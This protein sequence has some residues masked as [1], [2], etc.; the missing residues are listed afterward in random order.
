MISA[1]RVSFNL[2]L[3]R[4]A[5]WARKLNLPL[6]ILEVLRVDCR[7]ASD[8]L[9]RFVIDGM[10]DTDRRLTN[11]PVTYYPYVEPAPG[12]GRGLLGAL[13]K[14][15][16]VVVTDD[17]PT[18]FLKRM[19][20][21]AATQLETRLEAVDGNGL[22][23][24]A[25]ADREFS[26]AHAFRRFLQRSLPEHMCEIPLLDPLAEALPQPA[27]VSETITLRW[28]KASV[29]LLDG[30]RT[31]I[32]ALPI[33]HDVEPDGFRGGASAAEATLLNFLDR[34]LG[35][36]LEI[37]NRPDE[38]GT[39]GL[40]PYLHFGHLSVHQVFVELMARERWTPE[41]LSGRNDGRRSGWW[42]VRDCAEAF[43]D[44]LV[45]WRELGFNL[46]YHRKDHDQ[47]SAVPEWARR[48][49]GEH[50][51]DPREYLYTEDELTAA[52]THD[53][54]WNA[55]QRQLVREGR[56]H[57]YL[58]MLWGKKI[59]E[60]SQH[61]CQ[62][63]ETMFELNNRF[64]LDGRDPNSSSGILWILGRFDRAWGP[65]RPVF[66]KVRYMSSANT[67]RKLPVR[68]YMERYSEHEG[69][70]A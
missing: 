22:L 6:T 41:D 61:P 55:A 56:M 13:A 9:H 62:A 17:Y 27:P 1:R 14:Q 11:Q 45:T 16:A 67:A 20:S 28:P 60:W 57:N 43:L 49:L 8:R 44:Q 5:A 46:C 21:A 30:D 34:K 32:A 15:A 25:V 38:E 39:S 59:L 4:A 24:M 10:A 23:P 66:G 12:A 26:S 29:A 51:R 42:G 3:E 53:P 40:S 68:R 19:V 70:S 52:A 2:A 69:D 47:Y 35:S 18:F 7:W 48:T 33:D 37:R 64:A 36:Y 31:A 54:L 50:A 58:R 65:E 63:L